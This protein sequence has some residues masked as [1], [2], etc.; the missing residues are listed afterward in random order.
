VRQNHIPRWL[1]LIKHMCILMLAVRVTKV[2]A[3]SVYV[4][5]VWQIV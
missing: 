4:I 5:I 2:G 1:H 3:V